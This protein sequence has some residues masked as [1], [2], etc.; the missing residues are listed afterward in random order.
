MRQNDIEI[1]HYR[2]SA[3]CGVT[4]HNHDFYEMY[5]LLDGEMD[6]LVSGCRYTLSRGTILLIA[7][8]E[9]HRPD[10]QTPPQD[11]DRIVLWMNAGFVRSV[12]GMFSQ[13]MEGEMDP[14]KNMLNV[15][16]TKRYAQISA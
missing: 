10:I 14:Y 7:P 13:V 2:D 15:L 1:Y 9:L 4:L 8:G 12:Y 3:P 6:Y 16:M 11:Y 5:F